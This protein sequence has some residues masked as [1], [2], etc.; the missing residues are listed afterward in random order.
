MGYMEKLIKGKVT[1]NITNSKFDEKTRTV[2]ESISDYDIFIKCITRAENLISF[3]RCIDKKECLDSSLKDKIY[4]CYRASVVLAISALDAF[5]RQTILHKVL[6][7]I[8][9]TNKKLSDKLKKYII[10]R[11]KIENCIDEIRSGNFFK[12]IE[13]EILT[14]LAT[15]F[16]NHEKITRYFDICGYKNI[17]NNIAKKINKHKD[18]V[19]D[20][21]EK[22]TYRRHTIVH[23][24]DYN[25]EQTEYKENEITLDYAKDC[26][27]FIKQIA[28]E[29]KEITENKK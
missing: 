9:K 20:K 22:Y 3:S 24:G 25:T 1:K 26:I 29:I 5:I 27:S 14:D 19:I 28:K 6:G 21:F 11:I 16:Q 18:N 10:D 8:F 23:S 4:D 13:K 17:F 15:P 7:E 12:H 2:N